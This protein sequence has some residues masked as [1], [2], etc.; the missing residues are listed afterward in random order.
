MARTVGVV[1]GAGRSS[2]TS[3]GVEKHLRARP[4]VT[5]LSSHDV[6]S[7]R[8]RGQQTQAERAARGRRPTWPHGVH[9]AIASRPVARCPRRRAGHDVRSSQPDPRRSRPR[10][11]AIFDVPTFADCFWTR[12]LPCHR[13]GLTRRPVDTLSRTRRPHAVEHPGPASRHPGR[14]DLVRHFCDGLRP[15]GHAGHR[16][17]RVQSRSAFRK[18]R[19]SAALRTPGRQ[20]R[21]RRA[22]RSFFSGIR[23]I[24]R[25][26]SRARPQ[27]G[28]SSICGSIAARRKRPR[29]PL[30]SPH[31]LLALSSRSAER[32]DVVGLL[33]ARAVASSS[34]RSAGIGAKRRSAAKVMGRSNLTADARTRGHEAPDN[35][36][37]RVCVCVCCNSRSRAATAM[38][39]TLLALPRRAL[40]F[41]SRGEGTLASLSKQVTRVADLLR[42]SVKRKRRDARRAAQGASGAGGPAARGPRPAA[43]EHD[44]GDAS[45]A[46]ARR[47]RR[48]PEATAT[49]GCR[50]GQSPSRPLSR[51]T[52]RGSRSSG[53]TLRIRRGGV[54]D[55][56]P[57]ARPADM[58]SSP[59]S[60]AGT[61]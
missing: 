14:A 11:L 8:G 32:F 21:S 51:S 4:R 40:G 2:S 28:A 43:P 27:P 44:D 5:P 24:T 33:S 31:L 30:T 20:R 23:R 15:C 55:A 48:R 6:S 54:A 53:P 7:P 18:V 26:S 46:R 16:L 52:L 10:Y 13:F 41:L 9:Q 60:V 1:A 50:H 45:G 17:P 37:A 25:I 49:S 61:S 38:W 22:E 58:R 42:D 3:A 34:A 19:P 47:R 57:R 56:R 59:S 36:R 12:C 29:T 39:R 35:L